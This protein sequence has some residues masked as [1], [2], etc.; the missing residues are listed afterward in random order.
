[1]AYQLYRLDGSGRR[2]VLVAS[3]DASDDSE[4]AQLL[5]L[6]QEPTDTELWHA[7]RK[8]ADCPCDEMPILTVGVVPAAKPGNAVASPR[9]VS[10]RGLAN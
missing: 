9:V 5:I 7:G 8:V 6:R 1:M 2:L 3:F 4:A 10:H